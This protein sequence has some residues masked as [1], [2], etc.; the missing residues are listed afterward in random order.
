MLCD[1]QV[2][3][4]TGRKINCFQL[5]TTQKCNSGREAG[6]KLSILDW[7]TEERIVH[8]KTQKNKKW[9]SFQIMQSVTAT[10]DAFICYTQCK[11]GKTDKLHLECT[12]I[13]MINRALQ[14]NSYRYSPDLWSMDKNPKKGN[15]Q[16]RHSRWRKSG[17][18]KKKPG[19]TY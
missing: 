3:D 7:E 13:Y 8:I 11:D 19:L 14:F 5:P 10:K 12:W 6:V 15:W 16:T 4:Q 1:A 17:S 9:V 2:T 18:Q